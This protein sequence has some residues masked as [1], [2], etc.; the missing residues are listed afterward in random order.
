MEQRGLR[1]FDWASVPAGPRHGTAWRARHGTAWRARHGETAVRGYGEGR[2]GEAASGTA[3][4]VGRARQRSGACS[5]PRG[6]LEERL[7]LR[8]FGEVPVRRSGCG[9]VK[10]P[11]RG[12]AD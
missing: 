7:G 5:A 12:E 1:K 2:C 9:P 11:A 3:R 10:P 4:P 6:V 8:R